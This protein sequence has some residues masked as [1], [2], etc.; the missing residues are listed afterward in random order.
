MFYVVSSQATSLWMNRRPFSW[1][2]ALPNFLF[3]SAYL[4]SCEFEFS[5]TERRCT[6]FRAILL[7]LFALAPSIHQSSCRR[8][9]NYIRRMLRQTHTV[10]VRLKSLA[11]ESR[12][13]HRLYTPSRYINANDGKSIIHSIICG[14]SRGREKM[15]YLHPL[16]TSIFIAS[17]EGNPADAT[18]SNIM[19]GRGQFA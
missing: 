12:E 19:A 9:Q 16:P 1:K 6:Y 8:L 14:D 17:V 11:K 13:D 10:V 3:T 7:I 2:A 18:Q 4:F 5:L 15:M